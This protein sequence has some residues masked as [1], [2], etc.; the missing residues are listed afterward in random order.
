MKRGWLI[1][2]GDLARVYSD[3]VFAGSELAAVRRTLAIARRVPPG[4]TVDLFLVT[5]SGAPASV[6]TMTADRTGVRTRAEKGAG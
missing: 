3:E 1:Q 4:V 2:T 5:E 6:A